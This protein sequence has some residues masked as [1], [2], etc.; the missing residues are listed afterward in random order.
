[1]K[2]LKRTKI[3]NLILGI[4]VVA[5]ATACEAA[6][7]LLG[8][9]TGDNSV[10]A[11]DASLAAQYAIGLIPLDAEAVQRADVTGNNDV[12]AYDASLIAQFAIGLIQGF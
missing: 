4:T 12:S 5:F 9:V 10:S 8:D 3:F 11:Y 7:P 1:M 2:M 6:P